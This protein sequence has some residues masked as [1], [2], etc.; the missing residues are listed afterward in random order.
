MSTDKISLHV[1]HRLKNKHKHE[2][3][4]S[5]GKQAVS[6]NFIK[7]CVYAYGCVAYL[8]NRAE[9]RRSRNTPAVSSAVDLHARTLY[10]LGDRFAILC[11]Q[12][13]NSE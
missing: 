11:K 8:S 9:I 1:Q 10:I 6:L 2:G 13:K 5:Y 7:H 4:D 3:V 12:S